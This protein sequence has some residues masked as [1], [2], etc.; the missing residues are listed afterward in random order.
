MEKYTHRGEWFNL[1]TGL[2][3]FLVNNHGR[4]QDFF[5]GGIFKGKEIFE[6]HDMEP[7]EGADSKN[8][9]AKSVN[10]LICL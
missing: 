7:N 3:F 4:P 9:I 6:I 10:I 8:T 5:Q 2:E 1:C